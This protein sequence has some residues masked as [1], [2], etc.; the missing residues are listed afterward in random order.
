MKRHPL[1][2]LSLI[3]GVVFLAF[4]LVYLMGESLD[5]TVS[6]AISLPLLVVGLGGAGIVAAIV[7]QQRVDSGEPLDSGSVGST[8]TDPVGYRADG[9]DGH[10]G[11]DPR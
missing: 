6:P 4:A 10:D 5:I 7:G 9:G 1:E 3:S 2:P 11:P 8:Q